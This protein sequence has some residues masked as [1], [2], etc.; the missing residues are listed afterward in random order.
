MEL[1]LTLSSSSSSSPEEDSDDS[2]N[3]LLLNFEGDAVVC[4]GDFD[5][6]AFDE[7]A[8]LIGFDFDG[9]GFTPS[10]LCF[11]L[12]SIMALLYSSLAISALRAHF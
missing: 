9:E 7:N 12:Y 5:G 8:C 10:S 2:T 3:S 4:F 11:F 6:F 1:Q